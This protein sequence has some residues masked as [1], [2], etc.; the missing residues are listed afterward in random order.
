MAMVKVTQEDLLDEGLGFLEELRPRL[1][2]SIAAGDL[3]AALRGACALAG[4]LRTRRVQPEGYYRL[5]A[6]VTM[7]LRHLAISVRRLA[8]QEE[9]LSELYELVQ[10]EGNVLP[11]LYLLITVGAVYVQEDAPDATNLVAELLEALSAVQHPVHGIFLRYFLLQTFKDK[12]IKVGGLQWA[13]HWLLD[14]FA[15]TVSLWSRLGSEWGETSAAS[16]AGGGGLRDSPRRGEA[17][18]GA[19][20][21]GDLG[22]A[23]HSLRTLVAAHL[24]HVARLLRSR[25]GGS[26]EAGDDGGDLHR[27]LVVPR[28]LRIAASVD[29]VGHTYLLECLVEVFEDGDHLR[30][31]DLLLNACMQLQ[32]A[33]DLSRLLKALMQRLVRHLHAQAGE[34]GG[35]PEMDVDLFAVFQGFLRQLRERPATSTTPLGSLLELHLELLMAAILL[36]PGDVERM[37]RVLEDAA[38]LVRDQSR[39]EDTGSGVSEIAAGAI[40]GMLAAPLTASPS[41]LALPCYWELVS[42]LDHTDRRRAATAAVEAILASD[43][44]LS[45]EVT[46]RRLLELLEPLVRDILRARDVAV[47][48]WDGGREVRAIGARDSETFVEEQEQMARLVHQVRHP[49]PKVAFQLMRI[50]CESFADGGPR[51]A[52]HTTGACVVCVL[53]LAAPLARATDDAQQATAAA[54]EAIRFAHSLLDNL[55][56]EVVSVD[57][58][59][60]Y[61]LLCAGASDQASR[62]V[63]SRKPGGAR[64]AAGAVGEHGA[65]SEACWRS[66]DQALVCLED[67]SPSGS[68]SPGAS[69]RSPRARTTDANP[70]TASAYDLVGLQLF[71]GAL[72]E[73]ACLNSEAHAGIADRAERLVRRLA[74]AALKAGAFCLCARL[75]WSSSL[76]DAKGA[77]RC[78]QAA[79]R[80]ADQALHLHRSSISLLVD[81]Y[82]V[83]VALHEQGCQAVDRQFLDELSVV[84]VAAVDFAGESGGTA[85]EGAKRALAQVSKR[86][87]VGSPRNRERRDMPS[88]GSPSGRGA[89]ARAAAAAVA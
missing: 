43:A 31:L 20:Q 47:P 71:A 54:A 86:L 73:T 48:W 64:G 11:R 32:W 25:P 51:R 6:A 60:R 70:A 2:A 17:S 24:M 4:E 59:L 34:R 61:W 22:P 83:A 56:P 28:V 26:G 1:R 7:E 36:H 75:R 49:D 87:A 72:L 50:L 38:A 3:A 66:F 13:L 16:S 80:A 74:T 52:P 10:C 44:G 67:A 35:Q 57:Q 8:S 46:L 69:T 15:E 79:L 84:C 33:V 89:S 39:A 55:P 5:Y 29:P 82:D 88:P 53:R 30:T 81:A 45:E 77:F 76:H 37:Q 78:L 19:H 27:D 62:A 14:N 41:V 12:L 42:A 23:R 40:I 21:L 65:L 9:P 68:A 63:A 58:R 85:W 18:K